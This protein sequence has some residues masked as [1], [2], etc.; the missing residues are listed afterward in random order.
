MTYPYTPLLDPT[1]SLYLSAFPRLSRCFICSSSCRR[2]S[3]F[4]LSSRLLRSSPRWDKKPEFEGAIIVD[5]GF[6]C[7][8]EN[9]YDQESFIK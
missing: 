8:N 3:S 1:S 7:D 6:K 5:K 4:T 9:F 2:C